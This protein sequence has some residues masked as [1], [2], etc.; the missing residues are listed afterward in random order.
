MKDDLDFYIGNIDRFMDI[1]KKHLDYIEKKQTK[2]LNI[3]GIIEDHGLVTSIFSAASIEAAINLYI[4]IPIVYINNSETRIFYGDLISHYFRSPIHL[5]LK[6]ICERFPD[7]G[8]NKNLLKR[9]NKLFS[10]RNLIMH[11]SPEHWELSDLTIYS[12]GIKYSGKLKVSLPELKFD[13]KFGGEEEIK[14]AHKHFK[15]AEDFISKLRPFLPKKLTKI[16]IS[17]LRNFMQP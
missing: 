8:K 15:T 1:A 12:D 17:Q 3:P 11:S 10:Y 13:S 5:K 2:V 9:V 7:I 4:L 16:N 6:F 14:L